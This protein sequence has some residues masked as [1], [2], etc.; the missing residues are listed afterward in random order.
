[1][2]LTA[3]ETVFV[4]ADGGPA[5]SFVIQPAKLDG[6]KV[7][8]STGSEGKVQFM[9]TL[10]AYVAFNYKT[11]DMLEALQREGGID[12]YVPPVIEP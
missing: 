6:C 8:A 5:S 12:M 9:K 2:C 7:I 3:D 4:A 10:G 11:T 1:M